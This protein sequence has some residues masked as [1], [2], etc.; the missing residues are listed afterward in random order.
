[1]VERKTGHWSSGGGSEAPSG[2]A[3]PGAWSTE[4]QGP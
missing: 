1:M 4:T 2:D 3:G